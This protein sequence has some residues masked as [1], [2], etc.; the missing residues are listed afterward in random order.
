LAGWIFT[1]RRTFVDFQFEQKTPPV[2]WSK[3][4]RGLGVPA[5]R[6]A[7]KSPKLDF[8]DDQMTIGGLAHRHNFETRNHCD[9]G[10]KLVAAVVRE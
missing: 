1:G 4:E 6:E 9:E 2:D 8:Y 10:K 3:H 5:T 7:S